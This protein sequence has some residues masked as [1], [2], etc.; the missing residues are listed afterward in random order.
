MKSQELIYPMTRSDILIREVF[1]SGFTWEDLES[2]FNINRNNLMQ[3]VK[4]YLS[5]AGDPERRFNLLQKQIEANQRCVE[6]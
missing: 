5:R 3:E 4:A 1:R 6:R 2:F